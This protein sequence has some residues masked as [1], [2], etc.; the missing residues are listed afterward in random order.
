MYLFKSHH[1]SVQIK[2]LAF[3]LFFFSIY[4]AS[5]EHLDKSGDVVLLYE[6]DDFRM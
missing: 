1:S 6:G 2:F 3:W 4:F 5:I